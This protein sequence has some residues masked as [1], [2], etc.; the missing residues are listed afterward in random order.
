[1]PEYLQVRSSVVANTLCG[2]RCVRRGLRVAEDKGVFETR[3]K[4]SYTDAERKVPFKASDGGEKVTPCKLRIL[5]RAM[6]QARCLDR[7]AG[8]PGPSRMS[9]VNPTNVICL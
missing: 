8:N 3:H 5:S 4:R 6:T 9:F 7:P 1:M 2:L